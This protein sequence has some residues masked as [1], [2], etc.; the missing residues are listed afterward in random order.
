MGFQRITIAPEGQDSF[1]A[2]FNPAEYSVDKGNTIAQAAIPG[3]EAPILQYVHGNMQTLTME[4]FFDTYEEG[5]DVTEA[6]DK[7]YDL[8]YLDPSTHAPPICELRWGTFHFRGVL[9]HVSG[10]F[11]L[12]LADGTPV[13]ATLNVVFDEFIDVD[14]LVQEQPTESAQHRKTRLVKAGDR[15]DNIAAEE[16]G[17]PAKWRPIAEANDLDDPTQLEPGKVIIIPRLH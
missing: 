14:V 11:T 5:R 6:T 10:K 3:L 17:D 16:Y 1:Q 15:I 7:I 2:L 9:D 13:R 12:F 8:L 4:L